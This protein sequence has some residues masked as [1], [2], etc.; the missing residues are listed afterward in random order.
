MKKV[1]VFWVVAVFAALLMV[2]GCTA[3]QQAP[4]APA[5]SS[6]AAA[7]PADAGLLGKNF[8]EFGNAADEHPVKVPGDVGWWLTLSNAFKY[9]CNKFRATNLPFSCRILLESS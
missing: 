9:Q 6:D 3:V 5:A 2:A 4:A 1:N 7:A 8:N